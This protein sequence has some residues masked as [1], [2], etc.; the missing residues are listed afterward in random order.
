[1]IP[2]G[3]RL[4]VLALAALAVMFLL[5]AVGYVIAAAAAP[6][7]R[8]AQHLGG[9]LTTREGDPLRAPTYLFAALA[10]AALSTA[11]AALGVLVDRFGR[12][13]A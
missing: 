5:L 1:M 13:T 9:L 7:V 4:A 11:C 8:T 10:L 2:K 3:A 12:P 6:P